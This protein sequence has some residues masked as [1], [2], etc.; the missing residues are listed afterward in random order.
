MPEVS[1]NQRPLVLTPNS[2]A[3]IKRTC[4][5]RTPVH[6]YSQM[7]RSRSRLP[8]RPT[9]L[10]QNTYLTP[11]TRRASAA[12]PMIL[13]SLQLTM[14]A[15]ANVNTNVKMNANTST[16]LNT[17]IK[18]SLSNSWCLGPS[19]SPANISNPNPDPLQLEYP[20][21]QALKPLSSEIQS[22]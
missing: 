3:L 10:T 15:T 22:P 7:M 5:S 16:I 21:P 13:T 17:N 20:K 4:I 18:G 6:R 19:S 11:R 8:F 2:K 12:S 9:T 14:S 1:K